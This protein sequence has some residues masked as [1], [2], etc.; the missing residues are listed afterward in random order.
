MAKER[1]AIGL[2]LDHKTMESFQSLISSED[3]IGA[4]WYR[5]QGKTLLDIVFALLLMPVILPLIG[6]LALLVARDGSRPFYFQD[7]VGR[8]GRIF[9]MWKLRT[10]VADADARL[11]AHLAASHEAR[12]EWDT[13]QKLADDPRITALGRFLRQT[14]LDE[15][16][17]FF[18]VLAGDMS[19]VGPRPM[20]TCQTALYP[21]E[22]YY[23]LKPGV[24]GP[25]QVSD[26]NVASFVDRVRF[27]DAY[28]KT[29]SL[30]TDLRLIAQTVKVVLRG[31]GL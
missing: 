22:S 19:V 28:C 8:D 18:N 27:D 30:G 29:V 6:I 26:R 21:G 31:T 20:M 12:T 4:R 16:P 13:K 9:R 7:R 3:R 23:R 1:M 14:S 5:T 10:M 17:Q 24:T 11:E 15:L 25:W 2:V